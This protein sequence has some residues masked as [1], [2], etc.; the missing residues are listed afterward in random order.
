M[1]AGNVLYYG[2]PLSLPVPKSLRAGP[3]TLSYESGDLRGIR[4]GR[5]QVVQRIYSA[6]RDRD[7]GTVP[8]EISNGNG[9]W[10]TVG[11][12]ITSGTGKTTSTSNGM[13]LYR[14]GRRHGPFAPRRGQYLVPAFAHRFRILHPVLMRRL[15]C[16][17]ARVDGPPRSECSLRRPGQPVEPLTRWQRDLRGISRRRWSCG[18]RGHFRNGR[19]AN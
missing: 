14:P 12:P 4:L 16:R 17:I 9:G 1:L 8:N 7:W 3:M 5:R 13:R 6:V 10:S 11:S 19:P 18:H 2:S 15:T